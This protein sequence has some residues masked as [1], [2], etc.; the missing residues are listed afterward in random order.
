MDLEGPSVSKQGTADKR[1]YVT[2]TTAQKLEIVRRLES[3]E[4]QS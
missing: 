2:L 1:K 4:S 3:C